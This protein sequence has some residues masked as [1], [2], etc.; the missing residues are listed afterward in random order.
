MMP[1][2]ARTEHASVE[3]SIVVVEK[4][5]STTDA[6][7]GNVMGKT[8]DNK[9]RDSWH[10]F[11]PTSLRESAKG[12]PDPNTRFWGRGKNSAEFFPRPCISSPTSRVIAIR[13]ISSML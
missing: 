11:S 1:T 9:A 12:Y 6:V 5:G 8:G 2:T 7:L 4:H 3:S 13:M 10:A